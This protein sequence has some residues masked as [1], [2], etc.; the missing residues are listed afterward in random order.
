MRLQESDQQNPVIW[1]KY[2]NVPTNYVGI[3]KIKDNLT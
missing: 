1:I 3:V 2:K